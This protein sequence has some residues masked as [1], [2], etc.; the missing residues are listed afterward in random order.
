M[1]LKHLELIL[2]GAG[3]LSLTCFAVSTFYPYIANRLEE[4]A[5]R[6]SNQLRG[7]FLFMSSRTLLR[8]FLA[9]GAGLGFL[10]YRM[11]GAAWAS[12]S[13]ITVPLVLSGIA[14]KRYQRIRNNRVISQLPSMLDTLSGYVK[15][16]HSFP[17]ALSGAIPLLPSGIR[18]EIAWLFRLNRLGTSLPDALLAWERRIP[19]SELSLVVRPLRIALTGGGNLVSLLERSRDVL[20]SRQR[21]QD[22]MRSMT[23]QARLQALVLTMLPPVFLLVLSSMEEG[24]WEASTG[25]LPGRLLLATAAIL[26]LFGWLLI[27]IILKVKT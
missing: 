19:S 25:T 20:R 7:D 10:A 21:Q 11:T 1:G 24:F 6:R 12:V 5:D 14:V 27:R 26:Q 18:E 16:G 15:A 22:K 3:A 13:V 4:I 9:L 23:A 8:S 17:E 2:F